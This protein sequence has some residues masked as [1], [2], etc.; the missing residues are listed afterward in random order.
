MGFYL[1]TSVFIALLEKHHPNH[2]CAVG[3]ANTAIYRGE[4]L[5]I[6]IHV[7]GEARLSVSNFMNRKTIADNI[8]L[9]MNY[10]GQ[11]NDEAEVISRK[12]KVDEDDVLHALIARHNGINTIASFDRDLEEISRIVKIRY[13]N[14]RFYRIK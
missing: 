4:K 5:Y 9:I 12:H 11:L 2:G 14:P 8:E 1:D 3:F 13:F 7:L 6:S 10:P